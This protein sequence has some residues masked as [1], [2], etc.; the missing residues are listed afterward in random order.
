MADNIFSQAPMSS[1]Y[2]FGIN[3]AYTTPAYMSNFRPAYASD[4]DPFNPYSTNRSYMEALKAQ[5][6][7]QPI[8]TYASDP[9][10]D[11]RANNWAL[12]NMHT[13][14]MMNGVTKIGVP[15]AAW[16][17]A[18]KFFGQKVGAR[19]P[20]AGLWNRS[21]A[22]AGA[23]YRG[24]GMNAAAA[25]W[26][27]AAAQQSLGGALG[28][29]LGRTAGR[30][31]G[32][33]LAGAGR[34]LG[35]GGAFSGAGAA[36]GGT[37]AVLGGLVGGLAAPILGGAA[38]AKA[39][40]YY[41]SDP[42][43]GIRRGEDAMLANTANQFVGGQAAPNMGSF[44]ISATHANSLSRAFMS[45]NI[46]D[47]GFKPGDYAAMA[48]YGMQSGLFN[49]V[50]NMNVD[51]MKKKVEGMADAVKMIM[52]V[53]NT[54]SVKEA[55]QYMGRLK[56]AGVSS[57][58]AMTRVM[59]EIGIAS[60][61]SG[62]SAEQIMNTVG[63]QGQMI[64]QRL[65]ILPIMGQRQAAGIYAGFANAYKSGS[66]HSA[67]MA[68]MGGVEGATQLLM[69]G[70]GRVM[71]NAYFK[72]AINSGAALGSG[73]MLN[74]SQAMG[75]RRAGNPLATF[76]QDQLNFG[77]NASKYLDKH[78]M[79]DTVL[80]YLYD[81]SKYTP[82]AQ[83]KDGSGK[84]D[85]MSAVGMAIARGE[86]SAE[87]GR[88]YIEDFNMKR[89]PAYQR[90]MESATRGS[91][92]KQMQQWTSQ[93]GYDTMSGIPGIGRMI[94]VGRELNRDMLSGGSGVGGFVTR[95]R[96]GMSD[97]WDSFQ[98]K[99]QGR[100]NAKDMPVSRYSMENGVQT[101]ETTDIYAATDTGFRMTQYDSVMKS[102]AMDT[103]ADPS[104]ELGKVVAQ[105]KANM[106]KKGVD[107]RAL[108]DKYYR[109][110]KGDVGALGGQS[111]AEYMDFAN[112]GLQYG[113]A[114][115][116]KETAADLNPKVSDDF[117]SAYVDGLE[118][119]GR[120]T[121]N[122]QYVKSAAYKNAGFMDKYTPFGD[123]FENFAKGRFGKGD[124]AR[125]F[126]AA[127][128]SQARTG[129]ADLGDLFEAGGDGKT[130]YY[131]EDFG[132][133]LAQYKSDKSK[134]SDADRSRVEEYL[135]MQKMSGLGDDKLGAIDQGILALGRGDT[136][137]AGILYGK[138][139]DALREGASRAI[140]AATERMDVATYRKGVKGAL[141][142]SNY[143]GVDVDALD[144]RTDSS[145]GS[146]S[147]QSRAE[148]IK[149]SGEIS[150]AARDNI[151][152]NAT[153]S[154]KL[155]KMYGGGEAL[156]SFGRVADGIG[157]ATDDLSGSA[158]ALTKAAKELSQAAKGGANDP[159]L[160]N[161][162][163]NLNRILPGLGRG[164]LPGVNPNFGGRQ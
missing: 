112:E 138:D 122:S 56:A 116:T 152:Q 78:S 107:N 30:F 1:Y 117:L 145:L 96:A 25:A 124:G 137:K 62:A 113:V 127:I 47:M 41:L 111:R 98:A 151:S 132:K 43:I 148:M 77:V 135:A 22:Y 42:Y 109:L 126:N 156:A 130:S 134:L 92:D 160:T 140:N 81:K 31:M 163:E 139:G 79:T 50:G 75:S 136:Q 29:G 73:N 34:M 115:I 129:K 7:F 48:D 64:A 121:V 131:S 63:N 155:D 93:Q 86:L 32:G 143:S 53:A 106:G 49:D 55:I 52:A 87:E 15:L 9:S 38:I 26:S 120:A 154:A 118:G 74:V 125:V 110:K 12:N 157:K 21:A 66:I 69:E 99:I 68:A 101:R 133:L 144:G 28:S 19:S 90:R 105:L 10:E 6:L 82:A 119:K 13:D 65:G 104:S 37:G 54:N 164:P 14:A 89:D 36:L 141:V 33:G 35:M 44:G 142:G 150:A 70:G 46:R 5:Y 85:I 4:S 94:Q 149:K 24:Q 162:I 45:S 58:G 80:S 88:A 23:I 67:D 59:S 8:G 128:R 84:V 123:G 97:D 18:N 72:A 114:K 147:A 158:E 159:R 17:G 2:G 20:T 161:A 39:S 27:G 100:R 57:T 60:G 71:N 16:Y 95:L 146:L 153:E 103:S 3:P 61:V 51:Q 40:N 108:L 91:A 102:I 83:M 76:A 11:E